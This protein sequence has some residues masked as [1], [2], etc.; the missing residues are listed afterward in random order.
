MTAKK[1]LVELFPRESSCVVC[2]AEIVLP[3]HGVPMNSG[4]VLPDT[5]SGDWAGFD[6]CDRCYGLQQTLTEP[7]S[8]SDF[9]RL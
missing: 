4:E 1:F 3:K 5:F 8:I 7:I 2:S 9:Q 6:A